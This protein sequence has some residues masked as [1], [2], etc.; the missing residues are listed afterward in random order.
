MTYPNKLT[1][2]ALSG[3]DAVLEQEG[4]LVIGATAT[5]GSVFHHPAARHFPALYMA[6]RHLVAPMSR[7]KKTMSRV[8]CGDAEAQ[9]TAAA[10]MAL[11]AQL[12]LT[13]PGGERIV[14]MLDY[15]GKEESVL[16]YHEVV[17]SF[18]VPNETRQKSVYQS[19]DYL[20]SG[21]AVC[22]VAVWVRCSQDVV[23]DMRIVLSGCIPFPVLLPHIADALRGHECTANRIEEATRKLGQERLFAYN[24]ALKMGSHLFNLTGTLIK[25]AMLTI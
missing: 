9:G 14:S 19:V 3:S 2:S 15:F 16:G 23:E 18:F 7:Q 17:R 11:D 12:I 24:P 5:F 13:S 4:S 1:L 21:Q 6:L 8:L 25:R 10:L 22:G 20:R